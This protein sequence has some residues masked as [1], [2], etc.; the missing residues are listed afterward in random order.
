MTDLTEMQKKSNIFTEF[1]FSATISYKNADSMNLLI[2]VTNEIVTLKT[3]RN[4]TKD[5]K[6]PKA[7]V[8]F[9]NFLLAYWTQSHKTFL[10]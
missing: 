4:E 7:L 3:L 1:V 2:P 8:A 9:H 10:E 6:S 5:K